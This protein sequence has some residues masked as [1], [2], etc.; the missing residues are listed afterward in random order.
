MNSDAAADE[1]PVGALLGRGTKKSWEPGQRRR[2]ATAIDKRDDQFV[3]GALNIDS[4]LHETCAKAGLG[5]LIPC[6]AAT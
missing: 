1:T 2:Y 3:I 5:G 6:S 4:V